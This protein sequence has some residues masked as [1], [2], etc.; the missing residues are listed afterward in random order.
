GT[1][2]FTETNVGDG[3]HAYTMELDKQGRILVGGNGYIVRY[4][5]GGQLDT[6]F[7]VGGIVEEFD[8]GQI[9]DIA[10]QAD[11]KWLA[12]GTDDRF[13]QLARYLEDGTR[14]TS[15]SDDGY[16]Q[17]DLNS[18]GRD[19]GRGLTIRD[20]GDIL[21]VGR[22]YGSGTYFFSTYRIN[23]NGGV[24]QQFNYD[25]PGTEFVESVFQLPD[26]KVLIIGRDGS[27]DNQLAVQRRHF[28]GT[29]DTT[30]ADQGSLLI[31]VLNDDN[32]GYRATLQPDG[33]IL[34]SGHAYNG[35]NWDLTVVRM[36]YDGVLDDTFDNDGKL[37]IPFGDLDD[38][39]YAIASL[40][41]GKI[42]ITGRTGNEI[43]MVRLYGDYNLFGGEPTLDEIPDQTIEEDSQEAIIPLKG[44]SDGEAG[45]Q[46]LRVTATSD[47]V[48]LIPNPTVIYNSPD[49]TGELRLTPTANQFGTTTVT[50]TVEDGGDDND[51]DTPGDN[52][53]FSRTFTVTVNPA[54]DS[55]I[56]DPISDVTID[57]D[58]SEQTI[59]LSGILAGGGESQNL[60]VS[61]T[62]GNLGLIP[63]PT[64][65]Y[66]SP[67]ATGEIKFR[68]VSDKSG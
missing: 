15:F 64:V 58:A 33:K 26:G 6:S 60:R 10:I 5:S 22:A 65:I 57:E 56:L 66:N 4:L 29:L 40:P 44:I 11:G 51:L 59:L 61:A 27:G 48:D 23:V 52:L 46:P 8:V 1:G 47:N 9:R 14:D 18:G 21:M 3:R 36:S 35:Q 20:D 38:Y 68:P 24:E 25:L 63:Q 17:W 32:V 42:L 16:Q 12:F 37:H 50:V 13:F 31:P 19:Y 41:D 43:A 30:F 67:D 62:S 2:G 7:G 45:A 55:P 39:G 49:T 54:N 28:D 34:I 53:T